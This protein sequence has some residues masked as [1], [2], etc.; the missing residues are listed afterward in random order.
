MTAPSYLRF[1]LLSSFNRRLV[2]TGTHG[3]FVT[4]TFDDF[5]RTALT[6]GGSIIE[7]CRGRATYYA[8]MGLMGQK[9]E[10]GE[11]FQSSDLQHLVHRGHEL[12][13]HTF[14]HLSAWKA[15]PTQFLIDV[16]QC[17]VAMRE[18]L[19]SEASSNFAYP[20]GCGTLMAKRMLG[21]RMDSC[22][23]ACA[24]L[25]GPDVDLN[26]LKANCLYGGMEQFEAAKRLIQKNERQRKWLIF[27]THDV[28]TRPSRFGCT[29]DLLY[30]VATWA[31]AHSAAIMTI[32][33]VIA[34]YRNA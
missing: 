24:G 15:S 28:S 6:V 30:N 33:D 4:F 17:D 31:A 7:G 11:Y 19:K 21:T 9:S 29:P 16:E 23:G 3:P 14:S 13:N 1:K 8:A 25:N 18:A 27:C 20:F 10:N 2:P 26:W 34:K 5:P 12:A 22:R 32:R